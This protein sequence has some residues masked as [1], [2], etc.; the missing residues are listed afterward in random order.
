MALQVEMAEKAVKFQKAGEKKV[1]FE[2]SG[3]KSSQTQ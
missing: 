3:R 2:N 1:K